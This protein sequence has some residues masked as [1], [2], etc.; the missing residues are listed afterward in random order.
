MYTNFTDFRRLSAESLS[1]PESF[2]HN[3]TTSHNNAKPAHTDKDAIIR[4]LTFNSVTCIFHLVAFLFILIPRSVKP[5]LRIFLM[6]LSI[7]G[8]LQNF[9]WAIVR[10]DTLA[11]RGP[12]ISTEIGC[13]CLLFVTSLAILCC[14]TTVSGLTLNNYLAVSRPIVF[15]RL[16]TPRKTLAC[17]TLVW[18]FWILVNIIDTLTV[19]DKRKPCLP[20]VAMSLPMLL[21]LVLVILF[22]TLA[23]AALNLKLVIQFRG[24][25]K[26]HP[27]DTG[28]KNT[29]RDTD[30][31]IDYPSHALELTHVKDG[32]SVYFII[33][34]KTPSFVSST[35]KYFT[36]NNNES[37]P[38]NNKQT[39]LCHCFPKIKTSF[40]LQERIKYPTAD[41]DDKPERHARFN[42]ACPERAST[43][44]KSKQALRMCKG[45]AQSRVRSMAVTLVVLTVWNSVGYLPFMA[46]LIMAASKRDSDLPQVV[47][48]VNDI[49]GTVMRLA[50][51][52]NTF[53]YAWRFIRWR[54]LCSQSK[55]PCH[56]A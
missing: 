42:A 18:C 17:V 51:I 19:A 11:F 13:K 28:L 10:I 38:H 22:T 4:D 48:S 2:D 49:A 5:S 3:S 35:Q 14:Q 46:C 45:P 34:D 50:T 23:V 25:F 30:I 8:F 36:A 43:T 24:K 6:S 37:I 31:H 52:G 55:C 29:I 41:E 21:T 47:K 15:K 7:P 40:S 39:Q 44:V 54:A 12:L 33:D 32:P 26:V 16:A 20:L 27:T 56:I 1:D 53:I 9:A